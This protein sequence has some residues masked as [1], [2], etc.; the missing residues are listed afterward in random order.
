MARQYRE[1][2]REYSPRRV[3]GLPS[4]IRIVH[5]PDP[6]GQMVDWYD[7]G[8]GRERVRIKSTEETVAELEHCL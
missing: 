4:N 8:R 2:G 3:F 7:F 1:T 6:S 5:V